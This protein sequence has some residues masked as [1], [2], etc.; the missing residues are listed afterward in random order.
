MLNQVQKHDSLFYCSENV[1]DKFSDFLSKNH[2]VQDFARNPA[3]SGTAGQY[4][5]RRVGVLAD[6]FGRRGRLPYV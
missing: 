4:L 1:K 6:R 5:F 3:Y 2:L